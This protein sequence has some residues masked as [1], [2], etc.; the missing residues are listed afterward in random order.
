MEKELEK[1]GARTSTVDIYPFTQIGHFYFGEN[2]TFLNWLDKPLLQFDF[3]SSCVILLCVSA[4][5]I[6]A[7]MASVHLTDA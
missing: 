6:L 3:C 1:L 7:R 4:G 5:V 2:R